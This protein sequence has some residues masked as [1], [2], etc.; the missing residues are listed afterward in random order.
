MAR[1]TLTEQAVSGPASAGN[2]PPV[3][4][5]FLPFHCISSLHPASPLGF[6]VLAVLS[7]LGFLLSTFPVSNPQVLVPQ[8]A[9]G[10]AQLAS[11]T[12]QDQGPLI[13]GSVDHLFRGPA[14]VGPTSSQKQDR[15]RP[16]PDV[17]EFVASFSAQRMQIAALRAASPQSP[18]LRPR[19]GGSADSATV[20]SLAAVDPALASAALAAIEQVVPAD[21]LVP[22]PAA[23]SEQLAYVRASAPTTERVISQ[24]SER[25]RWCLSTAIYFEARGESY[26]GQVGVAQVIMNR[27][28]SQVFPDNICGVV[29]Q[30]KEWRNR[31]QFSFA[32]DG[33]PDRVRE[34]RAWAKAEEIAEKVTSGE[35]YLPEVADAINYHANYVYPAWAPRM[36]RVTQIGTH[37][38]YRFRS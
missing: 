4:N 34:P 20:I 37:I 17:M 32:C 28:K 7:F 22:V 15:L 8:G 12:Y 10:S 19:G 14:F 5:V 30:N 11:I 36:K 16:Q 24:F 31:C 33:I 25:D 29:F 23:V 13:V 35:L 38:F 1:R 3:K 18:G 21:S 9:S 27:V 26:R 2:G 6:A